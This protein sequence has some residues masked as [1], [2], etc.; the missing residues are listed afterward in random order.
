MLL[1][2]VIIKIW[3]GQMIYNKGEPLDGLNNTIVSLVNKGARRQNVFKIY[4]KYSNVLQ[5]V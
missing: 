5:E 3:R 1:L 4:Y 2:H